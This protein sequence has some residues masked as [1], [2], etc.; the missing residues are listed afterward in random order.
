MT[1]EVGLIRFHHYALRHAM[2]V[3]QQGPLPCAHQKQLHCHSGSQYT[4]PELHC[5]L[6]DLLP[7]A[8]SLSIWVFAVQPRC[9][10]LPTHAHGLDSKHAA[11]S[12][13]I[14]SVA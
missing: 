7:Q 1:T 4:T 6:L 12:S 8:F 2:E 3:L 14:V 9:A 13:S 11:T 5:P 10:A